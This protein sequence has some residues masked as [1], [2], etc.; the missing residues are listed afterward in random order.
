MTL[1]NNL[2]NK[3]SVRVFDTSYSNTYGINIFIEV[4]NQ[5]ERDCLPHE[6]KKIKMKEICYFMK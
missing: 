5:D 1:K 3:T 2:D 4:K 6:V